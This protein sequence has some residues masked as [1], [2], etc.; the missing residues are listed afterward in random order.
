MKENCELQAQ[1]TFRIVVIGI[2]FLLIAFVVSVL[3]FKNSENPAE[4]IVAVLGAV[5]GVLGSLV[6]YVAGQAGKEKAEER[7]SKAERQLTAVVDKGGQGILEQAR[8]A[9]PDIFK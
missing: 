6:G 1:L 9:Y 8:G 7:A 4:S 3:V 5:T 2:A